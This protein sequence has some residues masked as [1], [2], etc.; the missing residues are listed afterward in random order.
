MIQ[1]QMASWMDHRPWMDHR[2]YAT[3]V[4]YRKIDGTYF[5]GLRL[6][7][8]TTTATW[9]RCGYTDYPIVL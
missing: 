7:P 2:C 8:S 3:C 9:R 6:R 1:A 4:S 5:K